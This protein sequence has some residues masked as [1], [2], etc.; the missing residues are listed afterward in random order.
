MPQPEADAKPRAPSGKRVK[1][2]SRVSGS[3][4]VLALTRDPDAATVEKSGKKRSTSNTVAEPGRKAR[5]SSTGQDEGTRAPGSTPGRQPRR[6]RPSTRALRA[7]LRMRELEGSGLSALGYETCDPAARGMDAGD[8]LTASTSRR[9]C[10]RPRGSPGLAGRERC[11]DV[12]CSRSVLSRR[13][14]DARGPVVCRRRKMPF[15]SCT[16]RIC[17][18]IFSMSSTARARTGT[19]SAASAPISRTRASSARACCPTSRGKNFRTANCTR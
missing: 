12:G 6:P 5:S 8:R 16:D 11:S 10:G 3:A 2:V 7:R 4:P 19:T 14:S 15:P 9:A 13:C 17:P 18:V 1:A